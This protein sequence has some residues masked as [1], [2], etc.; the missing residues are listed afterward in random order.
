MQDYDDFPLSENVQPIE[1]D[2]SFNFAC[3]PEQPCF[4]RCCSQLTL[5][6]TPYDALRLCRNLELPSEELL[7]VFTD[8]ST[9]PVTGFPAFYLRM[10]ES[11][12]APCP[13][14]TP[15]GC[16]VY[17]DRPGACRSY[18]LGRGTKLGYKGIVERFFMIREEHCSG[19]ANDITRTPAEWVIDQGLPVYNYYNDKYMRLLSMVRASGNAVS[20]RL[21]PMLM[22]SLWQPDHFSD[23]LKKMNILAQV[24]WNKNPESLIS[25]NEHTMEATLDFGFDWVELIIFGQAQ[26]LNKISCAKN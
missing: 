4:N 15:A 12:D 13:F 17:E 3:G 19:F 8:R 1:R 5:P 16:S 2:C 26:G 7:A 21:Y 18:P 25:E 11:P 6:L 14:V 10:I 22:L 24:K 20:K 9:D 23:Y